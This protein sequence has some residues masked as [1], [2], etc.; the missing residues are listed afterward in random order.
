V[1]PTRLAVPVIASLAIILG[2]ALTAGVFYRARGFDWLADKS[3][4]FIAGAGTAAALVWIAY[5]ALLQHQEVRQLRRQARQNA[6]LQSYGFVRPD[7]E[8][9]TL[10]IA[11]AAGLVATRRQ[12]GGLS[13]PVRLFHDGDRIAF[14]PLLLA[15]AGQPIRLAL[16]DPDRA[17]VLRSQVELYLAVFHNLIAI[18]DGVD[19]E[20]T[21]LALELPLGRVYSVLRQV[22]AA[23]PRTA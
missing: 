12:D 6:F 8:A 11:V 5:T 21:N 3:A 18:V 1:K 15:D 22:A 20:L 7:L 14:V 2:T 23:S 16:Q 13:D 17:G 10:S 19:H 4:D 9:L